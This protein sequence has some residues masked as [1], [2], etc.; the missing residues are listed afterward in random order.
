MVS[1]DGGRESLQFERRN[2]RPLNRSPFLDDGP[3]R[4]IADGTDDTVHLV[5]GD[6]VFPEQRLQHT[7]PIARRLPDLHARPSA[8]RLRLFVINMNRMVA[9]EFHTRGLK[10]EKPRFIAGL[11]NQPRQ[12][13]QFPRASGK[14]Y[15]RCE[16]DRPPPAPKLGCRPL[17]GIA[18]NP[19]GGVG[20]QRPVDTRYRFVV[21]VF[22][23]DDAVRSPLRG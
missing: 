4:S 6:R 21:P 5:Q 3:P 7:D 17:T 22:G 1:Q 12:S 10:S 23:I 16:P 9:A 18:E 13:A 11:Q 15:F 14:G 8:G 2:I 20:M 19:V